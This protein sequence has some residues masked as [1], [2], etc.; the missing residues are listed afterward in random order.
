MNHTT[1]TLYLVKAGVLVCAGIPRARGRER[2]LVRV[3][4]LLL[5][6]QVVVVPLRVLPRVGQ[7]DREVW[8]AVELCG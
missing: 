5:D 1:E 4:D 8:V 2:A 3:V 7:R 6:V